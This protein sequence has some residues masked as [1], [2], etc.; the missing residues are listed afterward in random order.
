MYH[1]P[2]IF[3]FWF[4]AWSNSN[5]LLSF[6]QKCI[7]G[8]KFCISHER[9][10]WI[11][12]FFLNLN[13]NQI[14]LIGIWTYFCLQIHAYILLRNLIACLVFG[15]F[16]RLIDMNTYPSPNSLTRRVEAR[17]F[18]W[19]FELPEPRMLLFSTQLLLPDP[20]VLTFIP[21]LKGGGSGWRWKVG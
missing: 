9:T 15:A 17:N 3:G 21:A 2:I 13:H 11:I 16:A 6:I 12:C 5:Q 4:L 8:S 14:W 19:V 7:R 18:N 10:N 20:P 1:I